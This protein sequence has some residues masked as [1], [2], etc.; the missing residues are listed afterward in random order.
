M[1]NK[2]IIIGNDHVNTLGVIRTFGE[3]NIK[4]Y[5]FIISNTKRVSVIKSKYVE[6]YWI[7]NDENEALL[8]ICKEFSD[9][10][11]KP[12]IIPTS[13]N[14][15]MFIDKY[16]DKLLNNF[17]VPNINNKS[18]L[19]TYYM[20]KYNQYSLAKKNNIKVA[21]TKIVDLS[22]IDN[23]KYPCILKPILSAKGKKDDIKICTNEEEI[24]SARLELKNLKYDR[25]LYQEF[26]T[27]SYELDISGFA[28]DGQ[29][30]IPG[31]IFKKR[32]WPQKRGS[33]T[34]GSV[35]SPL[36]IKKI[37]DGI[38]KLFK[39]LQYNGIFD[40]D[41]FVFSDDLENETLFLN[42]VN[43]R[44]S[45]IS[46]AYGDSY[47]PYYWYLSNVNGKLI[48]APV[49]NDEYDF[50]DDQ[51]DLHNVFD[52]RISYK[53][54]LLDR[55]KSK[56]LLEKCKNDPKPSNRMKKNKIY[57]KI[58]INK[59]L[60]ASHKIYHLD[61]QG[62][63]YKASF[64]DLKLNAYNDDYE[65]VELNQNNLELAFDS[66]NDIKEIGKLLRS[67]CVKGIVLTKNNKVI[68]RGFIKYRGAEDRYFS[69]S[70]ND[71]YVISLL[72][73]Y[74]QFRGNNYQVDLIRELINRFVTN[75]KATFYSFIYNYNIPSI[76]N[77]KKIGF[78][79]IS[80]IVIKRLL[81]RSINKYNI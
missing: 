69:I 5:L 41:V 55:K 74:E 8:T 62:S 26:I 17:I 64:N 30:S 76:K 10:N 37:I 40:I 43:F 16:L 71:S 2:V 39:D 31:Y 11:N 20:D 25:V 65:V 54:Y 81:K 24:D 63:I 6:K 45:A 28:Y 34:Y 49:I 21:E 7:C 12:V 52:R 59:L 33:T 22:Q 77:F 70:R 66:E 58:K 32:I 57:N 35:N 53:E 14:A 56:I 13:D 67:G 36:R 4:P 42:E 29:I 27:Y 72:F 44:N 46:Y 23:V 68:C 60:D 18:G 48:E 80:D 3:N 19:M 15:T 51:A 38:K 47:V 73:V 50:M 79:K 75:N 61:N 1:K 9:E 78:V